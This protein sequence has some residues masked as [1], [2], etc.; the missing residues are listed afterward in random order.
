[1][2]FDISTEVQKSTMTMDINTMAIRKFRRKQATA[3]F[4]DSWLSGSMDFSDYYHMVT[5]SDKL[6]LAVNNV[7][8]EQGNKV[9]LL[10]TR[11]I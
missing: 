5:D 11:K 1:M 4:I 3:I 2:M 7:D 6:A 8:R 10:L 9:Q